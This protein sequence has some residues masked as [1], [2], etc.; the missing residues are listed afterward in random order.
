MSDKVIAI[1]GKEYDKNECRKIKGE[2]WKIGDTSIENSGHCYHIN[3]K[4]YKYNTGYIVY[5]HRIKQYIIK[6]STL[7]VEEG[8]VGIDKNDNIILGSFSKDP[9]H[10]YDVYL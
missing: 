5:D 6:N 9:N 10:Q 1:D 7:L 3:G 2:Y 4:Y 8:V